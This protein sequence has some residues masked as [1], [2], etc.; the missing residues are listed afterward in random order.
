MDHR[1]PGSS[2]HG[3]SRQEYWRGLPCPPP[4][5]LS[6]PGIEPRSLMSPALIGGFYTISATWE[7]LLYIHTPTAHQED[8]LRFTEA[9]PDTRHP[10]CTHS[11]TPWR[12]WCAHMADSPVLAGHI[13]PDTGVHR[14]TQNPPCTTVHTGVQM[15]GHVGTHA[16]VPI[17]FTTAYTLDKRCQLT[18]V[19]MK[20]QTQTHRVTHGDKRQNTPPHA[21]EAPA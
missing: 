2:V 15:H 5:D 20:A 6:N 12:V 9:A 3:F 14:C 16:D 21:Q 10:A 13:Q 17:C 1:P 7:A 19:P 11:H 8:A 4:G 18:P